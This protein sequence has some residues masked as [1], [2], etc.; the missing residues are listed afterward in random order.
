LF[1]GNKKWTLLI[2]AQSVTVANVDCPP[3]SSSS[4]PTAIV[5]SHFCFEVLFTLEKKSNKKCFCLFH[6]A[7]TRKITVTSAGP[8]KNV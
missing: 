3:E 5:R 4:K 7:I 1:Q 2:V 6:D 8:K